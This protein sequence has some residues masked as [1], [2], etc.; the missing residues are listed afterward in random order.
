M[1]E[2][3]GVPGSGDHQTDMGLK[4][5]EE[6]RRRRQILSFIQGHRRQEQYLRRCPLQISARCRARLNLPLKVG[7]Q[8]RQL[9]QTQALFW[10][11]LPLSLNGSQ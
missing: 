1:K 2:K 10:A 3:P 4:R 8:P 9:V 7:S 6:G 5:K 11:A